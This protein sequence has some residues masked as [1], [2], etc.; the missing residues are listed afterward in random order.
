[1]ITIP[2]YGL[3]GTYKYTLDVVVI[4]EFPRT[5]ALTYMLHA[6]FLFCVVR[7]GLAITGWI[8]VEF[9]IDI[10]LE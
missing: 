8:L 7:G 2:E 10:F 1:M 3:L 6:S 9:T 4:A 5:A